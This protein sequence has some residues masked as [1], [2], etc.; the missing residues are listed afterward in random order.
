MG[1]SLVLQQTGDSPGAT[2]PLC[3]LEFELPTAGACEG[4]IPGAAGTVGGAPLGVQPTGAF[5]T[6]ERCQ[7]RTRIDLEHPTGYLFDPA[8]DPKPVHRLETERLQDQQ[9][10]GALNDIGSVLVHGEKPIAL[11]L[12]C[13]E[14]TPSRRAGLGILEPY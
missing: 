1:L 6:L 8:S 13:Q 5:Q 11:P 2:R 14:M 10:K 9:V 12:D 7:Q 4:V 3:G